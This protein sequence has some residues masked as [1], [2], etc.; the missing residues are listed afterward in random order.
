MKNSVIKKI[1]AFIPILFLCGTVAAFIYSIYYTVKLEEQISE[2]DKTIQELSFRSKLV[3]DYFD[4]KYNPKDSTTLYILKDSVMNSYAIVKKEYVNVQ[5]EDLDCL[6]KEYNEIVEEYN[7]L[8]SKVNSLIKENIQYKEEKHHLEVVLGM[9]EKKYKI[10]YKISTNMDSIMINL[11]NTD[12]VDS[13]LVL[14][15]FYRDK[16]E[17]KPQGK[18]IITH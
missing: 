10:T 11:K 7:S 18:W 17:R 3:E 2:R 12:M 6:Y 13:G 16:I 4:I 9:I 1:I 14:L 15:P 5:P 8:V